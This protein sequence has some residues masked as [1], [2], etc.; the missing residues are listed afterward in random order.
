[1]A[2]KP[3]TKKTPNEASADIGKADIKRSALEAWKK[4]DAVIQTELTAIQK[5]EK[6]L[7]ASIVTAAV[8][9]VEASV[10]LAVGSDDLSPKDA[11]DRQQAFYEKLADKL[12]TFD[13]DQYDTNNQ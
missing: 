3:T 10:G 4:L 1:M 13:D 9:Y 11:V 12:P 6:E 7:N 5:G 2:R 8:K